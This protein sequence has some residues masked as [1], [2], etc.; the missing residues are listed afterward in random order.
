MRSLT[1]KTLLRYLGTGL[2]SLLLMAALEVLMAY[3]ETNSLNLAGY[4]TGSG[5]TWTYQD[6]Y[7]NLIADARTTSNIPVYFQEVSG[8]SYSNIDYLHILDNRYDSVYNATHVEMPGG[9]LLVAWATT[10]HYWRLSPYGGDYAIYTSDDG[11]ASNVYC[12]T[13]TQSC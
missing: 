11:M 6:S 1:P 4:A 5:Q 9:N 2:A 3:A 10:R 7:H 13:G 8:R 12:Y